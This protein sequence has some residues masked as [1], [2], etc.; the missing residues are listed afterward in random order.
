[1]KYFYLVTE[2]YHVYNLSVEIVTIKNKHSTIWMNL[3]NT[4]L[5]E[6]NQSQQTIHDVIPLIENVQNR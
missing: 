2:M 3:Q 5:S 1:M 4:I 6:R